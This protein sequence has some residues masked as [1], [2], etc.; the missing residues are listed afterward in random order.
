MPFEK[1]SDDKL[2]CLLLFG[3]A[4]GEPKEGKQ[5]VCHVVLNRLK[6]A[7]RYGKDLRGVCL[8]PYQFSCFLK[9]D[10]NLK[11]LKNLAANFNDTWMGPYLA[12]VQECRTGAVKDPTHGSTLYANL[13]VCTPSWLGPKVKKT[14]EI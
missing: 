1:V 13:D 3:E 12:I 4:R 14:V 11:L 2:L 7:P 5:G 6:V 8:R 10:P 9:S